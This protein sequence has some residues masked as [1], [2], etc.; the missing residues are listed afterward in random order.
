MDSGEKNSNWKRM[1]NKL[2]VQDESETLRYTDRVREEVENKV[3]EKGRDQLDLKTMMAYIE[4]TAEEKLE[5]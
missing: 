1:N 4:D 3:K 2:C 5:V